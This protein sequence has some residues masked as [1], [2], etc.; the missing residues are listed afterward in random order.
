MIGLTATPRNDIHKSTY[1]VFDLDNEEPNYEYD[2]VKAVKD[3]FLTYFR[4]LD[5]T[6][7]I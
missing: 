3:G 1:K 4:A 2:L 7:D 5:R 6:P